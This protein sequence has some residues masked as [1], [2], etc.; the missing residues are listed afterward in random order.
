MEYPE[1]EKLKKV[2]HLSQACGEFYDHICRNY[3]I[4]P[5]KKHGGKRFHITDQLAE[6]F[7]I[8]QEK[9]EDEKKQMLEE[10]RRVKPA[11]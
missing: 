11:P 3:S 5:L 10:L 8:D 6:F 9:L 1:H 2:K 4:E 7:E